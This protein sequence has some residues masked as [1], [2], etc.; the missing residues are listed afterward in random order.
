MKRRLFSILSALSLLLFVAV[1]GMW[2]RSY[3]V[4]DVLTIA[5]H[6]YLFSGTGSVTLLWFH[7]RD[8]APPAQRLLSLPP[9]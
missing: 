8:I 9:E 1:V 7:E 4:E 2:V 5:P 3:W 6:G